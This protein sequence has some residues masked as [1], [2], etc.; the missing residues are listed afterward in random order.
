MRSDGKKLA[1]VLWVKREFSGMGLLKDGR[2]E[3]VFT[4]GLH[5]ADRILLFDTTTGK[6]LN[7]IEAKKSI[8]VTSL[9]FTPEVTELAF[10]PDGNKLVLVP[11]LLVKRACGMWLTRKVYILSR[12]EQLLSGNMALSPDGKTRCARHLRARR[13]A[14]GYRQGQGAVHG[15]PGAS[16]SNPQPGLCA[17]RENVGLRWRLED[18]L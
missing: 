5:G 2:Q 13:A 15:L 11:R 12:G 18:R 1:C 3:A 4:T 9:T 16:F 6:Q 8:Q 10:T 14:L 7:Q 17:R